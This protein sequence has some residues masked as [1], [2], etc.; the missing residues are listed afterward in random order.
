M[1]VVLA[2][3]DLPGKEEQDRD[4]PTAN[5][6]RGA[7]PRH[8]GSASSLVLCAAGRNVRAKQLAYQCYFV[9]GRIGKRL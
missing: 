4:Q 5:G 2:T 6:G 1:N 7:G 3:Q 8:V 9:Q